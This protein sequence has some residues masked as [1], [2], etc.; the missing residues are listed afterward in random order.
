[1]IKEILEKLRS[2]DAYAV[3]KARALVTVYHEVWGEK[4]AANYEILDV[5]HEFQFPLLNPDTEAASRSFDEAGKIDVKARDRRNGKIVV[6][7][8]KTTSDSVAPD[9]DY[10]DRLRMDT[11]CSKYY[12]AAAQDGEE[13]SGIL[14]DVIGKPGQRPS[15]VPTLDKDG[16][17][18]VLGPDGFRVF[19]KDGKKPRE[20]GDAEKGWVVQ[21]A[22]ETPDQFEARLLSVLRESPG[23]YFAQ[24]EVPRLA[25]DLLEYM[26]DTWA[27]GQQLLYARQHTLWPRNPQ[28]CKMMGTCEMFDLCCGRASVD[29]VRYANRDKIHGELTIQGG[30]RQ[31]LT[32]SRANAYRRCARLHQLHYECGIQKVGDED[33]NSALRFGSLVHL[34][35][36]TYFLTLKQ[37]QTKP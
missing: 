24:R 23:D 8:H 33:L 5:E 30:E 34:G 35:L 14:Y 4:L 9:S 18:I 31:L 13:V 6:I 36:E 1:M 7:E 16:Y 10:W 27:L 28:A 37:N 20:T 17:K 25:S 19:T 26:A 22:I 32:N 15:L 11:Q 3:A 12:L 21:G 2:D 29:G